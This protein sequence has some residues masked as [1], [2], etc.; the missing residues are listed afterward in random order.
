[1]SPKLTPILEFAYRIGFTNLYDWQAR[2]LL[3]F[4]MGEP[5]ALAACNFSGKTSVV[6]PACALWTLY[7][8]PTARLMYMSA[9]FDQVVRQFFAPLSRFSAHR[10]FA[11]WQWLEAAVK[12]P[13][14]GFLYGRSSDVAGFVEGIHDQTGSPAAI[15]ADECK[16]IRD[17][18]LDTFERCHTTFRLFASS[19]GPASGGFYRICT[20][21]ADRWHVFRVPSSECS[22]IRN[23]EIER[24]REI[25]KDNI[26][27]IKH[28]AEWLYDAG[29]S[30]ISL[31]HVRQ[32]LGDPPPPSPGKVCAFCDFA[33]G[34][35]ENILAVT[36]GNVVR[37][38]DC[39]RHRDTMH[40]VGKLIS[41]FGKLGLNSYQ[42]AGDE[43]GLGHVCLDRLQEQGW[44]LRRVNNGSPAK[45]SD[46]F[47]NLAAE[48]WS[49]VAQ[50]IEQRKIVLPADEKLVSQLCSR[51]KLYDSRGRE[52]LESKA[53]MRA[54]GL[55]SCDRADA[56]VGSVILAQQ[57]QTDW[58]E[59]LAFQK[60]IK[61]Q[62][63]RD[64]LRTGRGRAH[65]DWRW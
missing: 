2:A 55:E 37:I 21:Q 48:Q 10:Y 7:N 42:I 64:Y 1:V 62:M 47:C 59:A 5:V 12:T 24:D 11:G 17:E 16:S 33:A 39:W 44:F 23:E 18:I 28:G 63:H 45:R 54:R 31:E 46:L 13:S 49:E 38:V 53:D 40:S 22:H 6:F 61:D 51:K 20:A 8:F 29:E 58:Q 9:T 56:V 41:L 14:G 65:I 19:T 32:L 25:L 4:E 35:D 36:E 34:G 50:L 26:F 60:Q 52:K 30:A 3:R 15:L 43:S 27:K 57:F